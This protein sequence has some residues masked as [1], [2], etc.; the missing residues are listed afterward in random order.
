MS[1]STDNSKLSNLY[2]IPIFYYAKSQRGISIGKLQKLA[3]PYS[4]QFKFTR[5]ILHPEKLTLSYV[6]RLA[7]ILGT[8][9]DVIIGLLFSIYRNT[10]PAYYLSQAPPSQVYREFDAKERRKRKKSVQEISLSKSSRNRA[11]GFFHKTLGIPAS[12]LKNYLAY[13]TTAQMSNNFMWPSEITFVRMCRLATLTGMDIGMVMNK[14]IGNEGQQDSYA[15]ISSDKV[16][17]IPVKRYD[18][19]NRTASYSKGRYNHNIRLNTNKIE[20]NEGLNELIAEL[21]K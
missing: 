13:S 16:S 21:L 3:E 10:K 17:C 5:K 4:N 1:S 14:L 9:P 8:R 2:A 7:G 12:E 11:L 19:D 20:T 15:Y 6:Y 18:D